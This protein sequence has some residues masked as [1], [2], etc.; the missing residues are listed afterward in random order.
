[1]CRLLSGAERFLSRQIQVI[2]HW[3][4]VC[5]VMLFLFSMQL[6]GNYKSS[7]VETL[8]AGAVQYGDDVS[9]FLYR[10]FVISYRF[11]DIQKLVSIHS[12]VP[13]ATCCKEAGKGGRLIQQQLDE[14][15][16]A[17]C[18]WSDNSGRQIQQHVG[19]KSLHASSSAGDR[20]DNQSPGLLE[21]VTVTLWTIFIPFVFTA[22]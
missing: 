14:C 17:C 7:K 22:F 15:P 20:S 19:N 12:C 9:V 18:N 5:L 21:R 11:I 4:Y 6:L 1:M 13:H 10:F 8:R 3:L 16:A 2:G